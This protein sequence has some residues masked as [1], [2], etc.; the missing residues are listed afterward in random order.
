MNHNF[1]HRKASVSIFSC[2]FSSVAG[3][4]RHLMIV[5]KDR[6]KECIFQECQAS[7]V[8]WQSFKVNKKLGQFKTTGK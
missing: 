3:L 4:K 5:H 1:I 2:F 6:S 7:Y 8:N